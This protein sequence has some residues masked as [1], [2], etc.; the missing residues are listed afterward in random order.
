VR[1]KEGLNED[2]HWDLHSLRHQAAKEWKTTR[3]KEM[4]ETYGP[5][6]RRKLFGRQWQDSD[7]YKNL[8]YGDIASRLG[9]SC[10]DMSKIYG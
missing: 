8:F 10:L 6:W 1:L 4:K 3:A 2:S 5:D 7:D 9:H